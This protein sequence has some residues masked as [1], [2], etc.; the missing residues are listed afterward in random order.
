MLFFLL[1]CCACNRPS[2]KLCETNIDET[3]WD[4]CNQMTFDYDPFTIYELVDSDL[5]YRGYKLV[6][7][8][9]LTR[10]RIFDADSIPLKS[11]HDK[12]ILQPVEV[13]QY[14]YTILDELVYP[15]KDTTHLLYVEHLTK[16]LLDSATYLDSSILIPYNFDFPLHGHKSDLME[17]PWYSAMAQGQMLSLVVR[18][19]ELTGKTYYLDVSRKVFN[20]YKR[21]KGK[22]ARP[23]I[24]CI[25]NN[26]N[27]WYEEY[28]R[29]FPAFTLNGK[30]FSIL[31]L[32][33]YYRITK[34]KEVAVWLKGGLTTIKNNIYRFRVEG[35]CS[36]YCLKH[37]ECGIKEYHA[38]HIEQLNVLYEITQDELFAQAAQDFEADT[39]EDWKTPSKK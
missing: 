9:V 13:I 10:E 34:D 14:C 7:K 8:D 22:G 26:K 18:L 36:L 21:I 39:P 30:I 32:Y 12:I 27:I 17:A 16:R 33:D 5:F 19:Y 35:D 6:A 38:L 15:A 31:G 28:P 2:P 20:S 3:V 29:D 24:S 1:V 25:D 11:V 23:W 37:H 4:P